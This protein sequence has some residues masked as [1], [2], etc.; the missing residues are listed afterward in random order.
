[1]NIRVATI[2]SIALALVSWGTS[3]VSG[4]ALASSNVPL[5]K[6]G[7]P[8]DAAAAESDANN[9]PVTSDGWG[10]LKVGMSIPEIEALMGPDPSMNP[11]WD[12]MD[13]LGIRPARA[14]NGMLLMIQNGRLA[15][16]W[17]EEGSEVATKE[18]VRVG[19]TASRIR[20][21][22]LDDVVQRGHEYQMPPAEYLTVWSTPEPTYEHYEHARGISFHVGTDGKAY[23]I[24]AGDYTIS[25][26]EGCA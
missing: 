3:I 25:S 23:A 22:Y 21:V 17:L 6:Y 5:S 2:G 24:A 8:Q 18:G 15:S 11:T 19:D 12:M 1:M 13:C 20:S 26:V 16:I 9:T 10:G 14:P 7:L 4:P